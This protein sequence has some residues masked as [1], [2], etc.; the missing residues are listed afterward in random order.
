MKDE[1]EVYIVRR[2]DEITVAISGDGDDGV[3]ACYATIEFTPKQARE[4]A[5]E[6]K[7]FADQVERE[8]KYL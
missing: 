6:L 3:G 5:R 1:H 8:T 7:K 2:P 4:V